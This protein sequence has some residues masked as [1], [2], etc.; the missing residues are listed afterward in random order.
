MT[1][2]LSRSLLL[3]LAL[4]GFTPS[5]PSFAA[6]PPLRIR[7]VHP[8]SWS[9]VDA[10]GCT[11]CRNLSVAASD[12]VI[13]HGDDEPAEQLA[14]PPGFRIEVCGDPDAIASLPLDYGA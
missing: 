1:S 4:T 11:T 12:V 6:T 13:E 7:F 3:L 14:I 10:D 5:R 8:E 9:C 2:P